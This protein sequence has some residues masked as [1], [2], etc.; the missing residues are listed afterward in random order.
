MS[1]HG[2]IRIN[3]DTSSATR[4]LERIAAELPEPPADDENA[5][6]VRPDEEQ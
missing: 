6:P 4:A 5:A 1:E 3:F 2:Q